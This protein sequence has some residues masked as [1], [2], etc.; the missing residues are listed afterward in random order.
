MTLFTLFKK[1]PST[2]EEVGWT[3]TWYT[4]SC[5]CDILQKVEKHKEFIGYCGTYTNGFYISKPMYMSKFVPKQRFKCKGCGK[6]FRT[7]LFL[8][9][10]PIP[11]LTLDGT[12]FKL[13]FK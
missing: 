3:S 1:K 11:E 2:L 12:E 9:E 6:K 7:T 5:G 10:K 4:C 8:K 13:T